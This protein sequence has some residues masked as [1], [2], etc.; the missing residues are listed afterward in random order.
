MKQENKTFGRR[1]FNEK[2]KQYYW[3]GTFY[4]K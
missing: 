4:G 1:N 3:K 2:G